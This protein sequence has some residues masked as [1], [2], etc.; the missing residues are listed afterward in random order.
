MSHSRSS[1]T[2]NDVEQPTKGLT[3]GSDTSTDT[4]TGPQF[5]HKDQVM[6]GHKDF[7]VSWQNVP[8][9]V[10]PINTQFLHLGVIR[11]TPRRFIGNPRPIQIPQT[12][13]SQEFIQRPF[14]WLVGNQIMVGRMLPAR[15]LRTII[16]CTEELDGIKFPSCQYLKGN[17]ENGGIIYT[18]FGTC[19]RIPGTRSFSCDLPF[20]SIKFETID[21]PIELVVHLYENGKFHDSVSYCQFVDNKMHHNIFLCNETTFENYQTMTYSPMDMFP[22]FTSRYF[23]RV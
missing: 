17:R 21:R 22:G 4:S 18:P 13:L 10:S 1:P 15:K 7:I 16:E 9:L 14:R 8:S 19:E 2:Q 3:F 12:S 6:E 5:I 11:P 20:E 23:A